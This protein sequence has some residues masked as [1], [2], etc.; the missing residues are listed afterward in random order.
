MSVRLVPEFNAQTADARVREMEQVEKHMRIC[1]LVHKGFEMAATISPSEP[2]LAE[3]ARQYMSTY[4]SRFNMQA[5]LLEHLTTMGL[6]KGERGE[7]VAQVLL[8]L[9]ADKACEEHLAI[10][11]KQ[12]PSS[13]VTPYMRA[14]YCT[15]APNRR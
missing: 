8:I 2:L 6:D 7:L 10:V 3:A 15:L 4:S 13:I 1:I 11:G 5:C 14:S 9:A 12:P